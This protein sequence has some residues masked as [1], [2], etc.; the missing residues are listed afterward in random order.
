MQY[1]M[2]EEVFGDDDG[3]TNRPAN[4]HKRYFNFF[5]CEVRWL[6]ILGQG[7]DVKIKA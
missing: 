1:M 4:H 5:G 2:I 3:P 6:W 7:F